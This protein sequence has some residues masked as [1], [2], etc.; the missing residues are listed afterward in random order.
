MTTL[1][2]ETV[3]QQP[4]TI[5]DHRAKEQV[6][7]CL[8]SL[9]LARQHALHLGRAL[10]SITEDQQQ[11]VPDGAVAEPSQRRYQQ[12]SVQRDRLLRQHGQALKE[13]AA[14]L[15]SLVLDACAVLDQI[16]LD[17]YMVAAALDVPVGQWNHLAAGSDAGRLP[18]MLQGHRAA[19]IL[20]LTLPRDDINVSQMLQTQPLA[21]CV[22]LAV[23]TNPKSFPER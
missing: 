11:W 3:P 18:P 21:A 14:Q 22:K 15:A 23:I 17:D 7:G 9:H 2:R 19:G 16:G 20:Y 10:A 12:E 13:K 1:G 6:Y 8:A 4:S 5:Q